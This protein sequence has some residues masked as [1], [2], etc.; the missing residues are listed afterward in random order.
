M[1]MYLVENPPT[2]HD[3]TEPHTGNIEAS[4]RHDL[5]AEQAILGGMMFDR[6][7]V[8]DVCTALHTRDYYRPA[9]ETIHL[10]IIR[11]FTRGE[12][13]DPIA[14][15]AELTRTGDLAR[16]GGTSYV[17]AC[18]D[19]ARHHGDPE[20]YAEHVHEQAVLRRLIGA[21]ERIADMG[22]KGEGNVAELVDAAQ[23]ELFTVAEERADEEMLRVGDITEQ[24]LDEME[25][26]KDNQGKLVGVPTGFADL[27]ALTGGL[28]PGQMIVI[29][30]RPGHGKSTL[31][32][33]I[34]RSAAIHHNVPTVIFSLEMGRSEILD[35]MFSAE[36]RVAL[37]HIRSGNMTDDDWDRVA[38]RTADVNEAPLFID[39]SHNLTGM[40]VRTKA[41]R[42][43]QKHQLG[44]VIVDYL[45]LMSSGG[46]KAENRQ[47]EVS[48]ISRGLKTLGKE[49]NVPVI[50]VAQLNRGPEQR[51][52]KK[53]A[54][55]DL[56]ESGSI[57]N[58]ADMVILIH[59]EDAYDKDSPRSGE[60]DLIVGKHRNGPTATITVASQLHYSRFVDMT[61]DVN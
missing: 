35:R 17:H 32:L 20:Y 48:D 11:L 42:L 4:P 2:D 41:R 49:L 33:D 57:E 10:A 55:S 27:D 16:A 46:G 5:L 60:A 31:S 51:Q 7:K 53:P 3:D 56:R 58:D 50:A 21:G 52:D 14:V 6:D 29:A 38:R 54:V 61:R 18:V 23:S 15:V 34:A 13:T 30:G 43:A 40:D 44:L 19:V 22:R 26:R 39:T 12:P 37:H 1:T 25:Q 24:H 47:L 28:R 8:G 9:H 59:R 36:A 45:Q